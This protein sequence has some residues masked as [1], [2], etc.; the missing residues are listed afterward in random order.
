MTPNM[1][2]MTS[3]IIFVIGAPGS[4]KGTLCKKLAHDHG[5]EHMSVG[6]ILRLYASSPEAEEDIVHSMR[7]G[8]L[9]PPEQLAPILRKALHD[10]RRDKILLDGFP[11][12]P[13]Q[14]APIEALIGAPML[15]LFFDCPEHLARQRFLT[16]KLPGRE[17]DDD[18]LFTKRYREF[19]DLNSEIVEDYKVKGVLL[20]IDTSGETDTSY[21]RLLEA[22]RVRKEWNAIKG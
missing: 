6:D 13:E 18:Q 11:R 16:R 20:A 17:A 14:A 8:E 10:C 12:K 9:L 1:D 15:V 4:G 21:Q 5:F 19:A 7:H 22:L 2:I 3:S